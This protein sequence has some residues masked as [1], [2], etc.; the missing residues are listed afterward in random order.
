MYG[1][2]ISNWQNTLDL[3]SLLDK[4][5]KIEFAICKAT[6]GVNYVDKHCDKFVQ[7]L[8][9]K[10]KLFG[11]YHF[12]DNTDAKAQAKFFY[13][14]C[15]GYFNKGIPVLDIEDGSITNWKSFCET[16]ASELYNLAKVYPIIY[17]SASQLPKFEN[18][19]LADK[20]GLWVAGYPQNYTT[21][22]N[23]N[24]PYNIT[25]WKIAAIWQ[26]TSTLSLNGYNSNLDGNIAYMDAKAWAKYANNATS[27]ATV[28]QPNTS[29]VTTTITLDAALMRIAQE[30]IK[31]SYG[32][33]NARKENIYKAVQTKVNE[34]CK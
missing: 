24:M 14:N 31:G 20:C 22:G 2:D 17:T 34:L 9:K 32:N 27:N 6:Q 25:P 10:N 19:W 23:Y 18:S 12:A 11:F 30:V 7:T 5:P 8:V 1:I 16:F 4:N 29:K 21:F 13:M 28:S 15:K 26:F 33:G 3:A